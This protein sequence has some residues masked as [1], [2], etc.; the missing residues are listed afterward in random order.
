M[1]GFMKINHEILDKINN[2]QTYSI[3]YKCKLKEVYLYFMENG[4]AFT[5]H[6]LGRIV[7]QKTGK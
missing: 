3:E 6:A 4:F 7:G 1:D 5:E 2:T